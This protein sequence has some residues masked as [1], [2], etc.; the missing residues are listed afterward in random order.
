[1]DEVR[2]TFQIRS[3]ADEVTA[4]R[5][6]L[7]MEL[8]R[9]ELTEQNQLLLA[10]RGHEY[11][12]LFN[13]EM[14]RIDLREPICMVSLVE[15]NAGMPATEFCAIRGSAAIAVYQMISRSALRGCLDYVDPAIGLLNPSSRELLNEFCIINGRALLE[16]LRSAQ[17]L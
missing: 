7:A 16:W 8:T 3:P 10:K 4:L 9:E 12:G 15:I 6:L 2:R 14:I 13:G 11:Q 1:M 17:E 5:N